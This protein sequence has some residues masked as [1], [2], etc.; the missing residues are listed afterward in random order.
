VTAAATAC[1][2]CAFARRRARETGCEV[3]CTCDRRHRSPRVVRLDPDAPA[4]TRSPLDLAAHAARTTTATEDREATRV[5][6]LL[7]GLRPDYPDPLEPMPDAPAQ[8]MAIKAPSR[9]PWDVDLPRGL[10]AMPMPTGAGDG[11]PEV[12]A[13]IATLPPDAAAVLR[14]LRRHASLSQGLRGLWVDVG[15]AFAS[16]A[17]RE[18]WKDLTVRRGFAPAHGRRIALA[19]ADAWERA[20]PDRS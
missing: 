4:P 16:A 2:D 13:R 9:A 17:Q 19:A 5:R 14:W 7:A 11:A 20:L 6:V 1:A 8:V 18:A 10:S 12:L 3:I 15:E